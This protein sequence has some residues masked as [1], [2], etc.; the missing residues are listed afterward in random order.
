[1][2]AMQIS[3]DHPLLQRIV[4]DLAEK[5]WSQQNSFLPQALTL[6]LAA[7]CRKRAA[8]GELAP[9]AVGRGPAQEIREGIRGDH[10]QWLEEG[11]AVVCDRY[12]TVMDSLRLAINR[13]L[14]LGLEEIG[15]AH[16]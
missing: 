8:E 1:M 10:I 14:F 4:D 12:M 15:R 13:S 11:D 3:H 9:A 7:E 2:R 16:V 5:G 6:E